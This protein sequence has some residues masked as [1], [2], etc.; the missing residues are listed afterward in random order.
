[1]WGHTPLPLAPRNLYKQ[2]SLALGVAALLFLEE[3]IQM[4]IAYFDC[5]CGASGDMLLA[6]LLDAGMKLDKVREAIF[7]L[8]LGKQCS[9]RSRKVLKNHISATRIIIQPSKERQPPRRLSDIKK[10]IQD[11]SLPDEV[12]TRSIRV[13]Q[14]LGN[15]EAKI[16]RCPIEEIHFHEVGAV[17]AI[18]D[19]VGVLVALRVLDIKQVFASSLPLGSGFTATEHGNLP[20]PAPATIELLKGVPVYDSG[21]RAEMVTP[22][23]A[24]LLTELAEQFGGLPAMKILNVGYGAGSR[25]IPDRPNIVRVIIGQRN[26]EGIVES[27]LVGILET[28]I[29]DSSPELLGH[30]M[31]RLLDEGALDVAFFP[32]QMKKNRPGAKVQ[33]ISLPQ[34]TQRLSQIVFE[35]TTTLGIRVR[36]EQ[37]WV[38]SRDARILDSPWGKIKVKVV[39]SQGKDVFVP[40][41]EECRT[42]ASK[43]KIPLKQV[44]AWVQ[45]RGTDIGNSK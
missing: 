19:I 20:L 30:L 24:A 12:K 16:H 34:D 28:N 43:H 38:A 8:G 21:I 1:V 2:S 26:D 22:T 42:I 17:D 35:E 44:Y 32:A 6:S 11:S 39:K 25:D 33:V 10:I 18:V 14:R 15:V 36:F 37:R 45:G 40:E 29:D 27:D 5:S 13:F 23:G 4:K 7:S 9:I 3:E 31:A 41:Y